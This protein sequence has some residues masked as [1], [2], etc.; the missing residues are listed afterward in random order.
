[1][2]V[3]PSVA[4]STTGKSSN[5]VIG[6]T[7]FA[8]VSVREDVVLAIAIRAEVDRAADPVGV[9]V[10]AAFLGPRDFG[11]V[12]GLDI[13]DPDA[14]HRAAAIVLPLHRRVAERGVGDELAIGRIGR[15][16]AVGN[17]QLRRHA[18]GEGDREELAMPVVRGRARRREEDRLA[19]RREAANGISAGMPGEPGRRAAGRRGWCRHRGCRRIEH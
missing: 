19:I 4:M 7:S 8:P 15:L 13:V 10:V 12:M 9:E 18:A 17:G 2:S 3:L 6:F 14:T 11:H 16:H 1:M 5:L